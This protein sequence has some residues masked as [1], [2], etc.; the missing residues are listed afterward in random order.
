MAHR[1]AVPEQLTVAQSC[2]PGE[3]T[4]LSSPHG[5]L[6]C[7]VSTASL[8]GSELTVAFAIAFDV[9][10]LEG[11]RGVFFDAKGGATEPEPRLGWTRMGTWTVESTSAGGD[12]WIATEP[13]DDEQ[14]PASTFLTD[15]GRGCSSIPSTPAVVAW[16]A[17]LAALR[18]R[19]P[20]V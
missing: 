5:E 8:S 3:P 2:L 4:V 1:L 7:G 18:R 12:P 16:I 6:H 15:E 17:C 14:G 20:E 13:L 9:A 11:E 19:Y 10:S